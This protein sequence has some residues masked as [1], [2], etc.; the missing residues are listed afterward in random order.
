MGNA[1]AK[2]PKAVFVYPLQREA[3]DLLAPR[4]LPLEPPQWATLPA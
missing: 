2:T 4:P 1:P 3:G